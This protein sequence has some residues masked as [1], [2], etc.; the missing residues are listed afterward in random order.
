MA[1]MTANNAELA[2]K[3]AMIGWYVFPCKPDKTPATQH[4]YHDATLDLAQVAA[5]WKTLPEAVIGIACS[6]SGL[7]VLDLDRHP[8][9]PDG[10]EAFSQLA[11]DIGHPETR[12]GPVQTTPGNGCHLIF[13]APAEEPG[14]SIP[15]KLIPG[16]DIRYNGYI[17][18]GTLPDGRAY[19]WQPGHDYTA[20]LTLPPP[21][22]ARMIVAYNR[23]AAE[24]KRSAAPRPITPGSLSPGDDFN[25]RAQWGQV[26]EGWRHSGSQSDVEYWTRPGKRAGISATV[27][28]SGKDNLYVW[29]T[30]TPPLEAEHSYSKFAA[31]ALLH[32]DGDYKAAARDLA[33]KGYGKR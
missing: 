8:G 26:L 30:S 17:C 25:A 9:A 31:Y 16:V 12:V 24:P 23:M 33:A 21:W 5:W 2:R 4:G 10:V 19:Q 1:K 20:G 14:I 7:F 32:H 11:T 28:Y 18:T 22:I 27:N 29:T 3:L 15:A 6:M 13:T